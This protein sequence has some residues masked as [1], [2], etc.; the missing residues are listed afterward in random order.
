LSGDALLIAN[1]SATCFLAGLSWV[2][3][4]VHFPLMSR[5]GKEEFEEFVRAS[6]RRNTLVMAAPMTVEAVTAVW[7]A[8]DAPAGG[9]RAVLI[10]AC[11]LAAVIWLV[12]FGW[13]VP[14]HARLASEFDEVA[15]RKLLNR[16]WIRTAC[17]TARAG[18]MI[19]TATLRL[20]I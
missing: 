12:T 20:H 16:S 3:Q 4:L 15:F 6:R 7:L 14:L 11:V 18:A 8:V 2:L 17:W 10:A 5:V 13:I 19:C 9:E 1:L